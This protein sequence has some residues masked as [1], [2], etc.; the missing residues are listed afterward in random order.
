MPYT[1]KHSVLP[2]YL[3]VH[4]KG[5]I[6]PGKEFKEATERWSMVAK[7][8]AKE[9]RRLIL[10]FVDLE[11]QHPIDSKFKLVDEEEAF[12]W[13]QDYKLSM[14]VNDRDQYN[15]LSFTETVMNNLGYEMKI[16]IKKREGIKWL[17][18]S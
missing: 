2:D 8:C 5:T 18:S 7:L 12:G 16:F 17:L 9:D 15:H 4:I 6:I 10:A 1:I 3:E 13:S 14:V 11:G